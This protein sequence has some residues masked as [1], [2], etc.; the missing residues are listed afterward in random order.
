[1]LFIFPDMQLKA[2][3]VIFLIY[4]E[5]SVLLR[6]P[7]IS[8]QG[9]VFS[10]N[11]I[12]PL[13][14]CSL[15]LL[16][17]AYTQGQMKLSAAPTYKMWEVVNISRKYVLIVF[18]VNADFCNSVLG[19]VLLVAIF[20]DKLQ[21]KPIVLSKHLVFLISN[22]FASIVIFRVLLQGRALVLWWGVVQWM[23]LQDSLAVSYMTQQMYLPWVLIMMN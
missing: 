8:T 2:K 11:V 3:H 1:M 9:L 23:F 12:V 21:G 10:T 14:F 20:F 4:A 18:C 6:L 22:L 16:M 17:L 19:F 15:F 13:T 5:L 7:Y